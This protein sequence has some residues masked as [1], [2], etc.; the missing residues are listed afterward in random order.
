MKKVVILF[1]VICVLLIGCSD[2]KKTETPV[3]TEQPSMN[4]DST[5]TKHMY[6]PKPE[7]DKK[8]QDSIDAAHGHSH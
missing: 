8:T 2:N 6:N 1:S 4:G 5:T 3:Q 7:V